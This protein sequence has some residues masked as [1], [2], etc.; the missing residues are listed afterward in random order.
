MQRQDARHA[1]S[2]R[3][4]ARTRRPIP[5]LI[6]LLGITASAVEAQQ[7][8]QTELRKLGWL[9]GYWSG[10]EAETETMECWSAPRG[11]LMLGWNRTVRAGKGTSFE[12]L[13]I[14]ATADGVVYYASPGGREAT[15][16]KLVEVSD[17]S[18]LFENPE[19]D[20]PQRI[21]YRLGYRALQ[22]R[23]EATADGENR[24]LEWTWSAAEFPGR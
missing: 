16:F 5:W 20:F 21:R 15:P 2:A 6:L 1:V 14:A 10:W 4:C 17:E 7:S 12:F 9:A 19:H 18:A 24:H 3:R 11:G 13:R 22:V 23:V 8:R